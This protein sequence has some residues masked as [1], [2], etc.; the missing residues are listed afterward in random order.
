MSLV[1]RRLPPAGV[2]LLWAAPEGPDP[3]PV[4]VRA[5]LGADALVN[6]ASASAPPKPVDEERLQPLLKD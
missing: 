4:V 2:S 5:D 3:Q 1:P 6:R